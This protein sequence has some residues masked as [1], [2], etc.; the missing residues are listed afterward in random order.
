MSTATPLLVAPAALLTGAA[1]LGAGTYASRLAGTLLR[2]RVKMPPQ[3]ER[4]L[5]RGVVVLLAAL[6]GTAALVEGDL[7]AGPA[8]V[9]GVAVGGLLAWRKAPFVVVVPAAALTAAGL[10]LLGLP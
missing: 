7:F 2:T 8:R 5:N 10:R 1:V 6:V 4:L 9:L 3:V